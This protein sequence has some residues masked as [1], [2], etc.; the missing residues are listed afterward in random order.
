MD[1]PESEP[2]RRRTLVARPEDGRRPPRLESEQP[3]RHRIR[4]RA[5]G[6]SG[7]API[8]DPRGRAARDQRDAI[9]PTTPQRGDMYAVSICEVVSRQASRADV[10]GRLPGPL[11]VR[12]LRGSEA[13]EDGERHDVAERCGCELQLPGKGSARTLGGRGLE[14]SSRRGGRLRK[15]GDNT[16]QSQIQRLVRPLT[17]EHIRTH[18]IFER[19]EMLGCGTTL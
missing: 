16:L 9:A 4:R 15:I 11:R 10:K 3:G 6:N 8:R 5:H 18:P 17:G 14:F 2:A 1:A 7:R 12:R 13:R 19:D